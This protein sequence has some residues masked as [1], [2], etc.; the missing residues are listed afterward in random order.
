MSNSGINAAIVEMAQLARDRGHRVIA[1]TSLAHTRSPA[2]RLTGGLH[3][4]D[5]ADVVID[6]CAPAGDAGIE[7]APGVRVG[8]VSSLT[9]VVIAQVLTELV[10]RHLLDL[11]VAAPVFTSANLAA[12]DGDNAALWAR[13]RDR[14]RPIEP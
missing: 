13:Y 9:G 2:A 1:V 7:L 12:G 8:A 6:N 14:V 10:C 3:L 5:L 11:G 4:A